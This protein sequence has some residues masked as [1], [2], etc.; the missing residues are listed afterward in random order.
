GGT[1]PA[2]GPPAPLAAPTPPAERPTVPPV[3]LE[4]NARMQLDDAKA[5]E[6]SAGDGPFQRVA[7]LRAYQDVMDTYPGTKA[8]AEAGE[9]M[10]RLRKAESP[11][12]P[13]AQ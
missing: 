6:Q 1:A 11:E 10:E 8:A 3:L 4:V 2:E 7:V 9:A 12:P 5:F 13:A